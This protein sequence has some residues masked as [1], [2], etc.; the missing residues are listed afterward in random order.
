MAPVSSPTT[1]AAVP[2]LAHV[3]RSDASAPPSSPGTGTALRFLAHARRNASS[4]VTRTPGSEFASCWRPRPPL[5]SAPPSLASPMWAAAN[6][7]RDVLAPPSSPVPVPPS[8]RDTPAP[9]SSPST[10][11]AV[12]RLAHARRSQRPPRRVGC[13]D[14]L[15]RPLVVRTVSCSS[16]RASLPE[17]APPLAIACTGWPRRSRATAPAPPRRLEPPEPLPE[18]AAGS[19]LLSSAARARSRMPRRG[20]PPPA[21]P[22][23]TGAPATGAGAPSHRRR[24]PATGRPASALPP[25]AKPDLDRSLRQPWSLGIKHGRHGCASSTTPYLPLFF[26]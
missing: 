21:D 10:S 20:A 5:R 4:A 6:G 2:H 24:V 9:P 26:G 1:G 23:A 19:L 22:G 14:A 8:F 12:L 13:R 18:R 17:T 7:R 25:R 3:G 11:V 16:S 15:P